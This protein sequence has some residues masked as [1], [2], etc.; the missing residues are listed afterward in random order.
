MGM[1]T[2][3][4][5][6][7]LLKKD[8]PKEVIQK[9]EFMLKKNKQDVSINHPLFETDRWHFMLLCDSYYFDAKSSSDLCFD[10][11]VDEYYLNIRCNLKNYGHE[12]EKFIDWIKPY[13]DKDVGE[14]LGFYR[15]E[16][17]EE[18]TLIYF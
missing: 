18:P 15:Y 10:E 16:E 7:S 12:I 8:A 6:N 3:F 11:I 2:E 4:H 1:Y 17:S 5:F 13:L 9:L 14:F